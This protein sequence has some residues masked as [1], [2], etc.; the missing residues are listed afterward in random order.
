MEE[1]IPTVEEYGRI[2]IELTGDP[3]RDKVVLCG[4]KLPVQNVWISAD[5]DDTR[6]EIT[7][8]KLP[9]GDPYKVEG[10]LI[11][12]EDYDWLLDHKPMR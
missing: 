12:E 5:Q 2:E 3:R 4:K 9:S 6:I 7:C 1:Q 10:Y 11:S 8:V